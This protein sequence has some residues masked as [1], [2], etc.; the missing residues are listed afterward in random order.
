MIEVNEALLE[1]VLKQEDAAA[2]VIRETVKKG[3]AVL[4][5][6]KNHNISKPCAVGK[7]LTTKVN[8]NI[9]LSVESSTIQREIKKME[10]AVAYGADA[11]M[12]LS[13]GPDLNTLRKKVIE[14][15]QVPLGT[16][17]VYE[18]ACMKEKKFLSMKENDFVDVVQKQAEEGVDFFTIHSGITLDAMKIVER[19]ERIMNIV[20]RGGALLGSWMIENGKENPFLSRFDDIL[21]ICKEYE[22]TLSLG[23]SLR[24]GAI[25]DATD[26]LQITE[27]LILGDLQKRALDKGV[28]VIIEG[29]GHVP[30]D[31]IETNV[32]L[33]KSLCNGAPFYVLG[34]LVTDIA[35]G[36]DHITGAIGGAIAAWHGADFLCY[37]TPAEHLRLPD[38][39]DVRLGVMASKIAAHAADIVKGIP[40]AIKRNDD[41]SK[42]RAKRD[43]KKQFELSLDPTT[44]E[45]MRKE[46]EPKI[47][48]VCTM[49]SEYCSIK[50]TEESIKKM[51]KKA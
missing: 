49:C 39:D 43:W 41:I 28:Q 20:S 2:D 29:P 50:V 12:D 19:D 17:P 9:G 8:A 25:S 30:L 44:A 31:Q 36:Y 4:L 47:E 21:D 38:D 24:P 5:K 10:T 48:D 11:V 35:P 15:C 26:R 40:S 51:A 1:S 37:V 7:G 22:V 32:K 13:T 42:A 18:L 14:E 6:N 34:P 45:K 3:H 27:L 46:E 33:Q 23:D 16:V